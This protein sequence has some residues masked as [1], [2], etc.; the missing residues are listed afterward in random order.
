MLTI[1]QKDACRLLNADLASRLD[2]PEREQQDRASS[3]GRAIDSES[4]TPVL[5]RH[6]GWART[7]K[8]VA[9][10]LA[11]TD[12]AT[13]RRDEFEACGLYAFVLRS[14]DDPDKYR[15]AG[16]CCRDRFCI[17]CATERSCI[18]AANVVEIIGT[19][20][21]RFLTLT[22]KTHAEPLTDQLDK[23][24]RSFQALR[25]RRLWSRHVTGGVAFL[26]LKWSD[27]G[28]RW[29][30]HLHCLIEGTWIDKKELQRCWREITGDS[31]VVDIR[32]PKSATSVTRYVT[33]YASK[34][35]N[36]TYANRPELLDEAIIALAG[37]KLCVTFGRW[38]GKLLTATP[39]EGSWERIGSLEHFISFAADGNQEA[40]DIL[41]C[42]TDRDLTD[43]LAR[44]PPIIRTEVLEP[45][46]D[47]QQDF[48]GT[49]CAD[50]TFMYRYG[51]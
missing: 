33:K 43:L 10:A 21:V 51:G 28:Q 38:R 4:R 13:S 19:H 18:I 20:E 39:D 47:R 24:Y 23:L 3:A 32:L 31:F 34:P 26:E 30:P 35:I 44:A 45:Q 5:F 6:S 46:A 48:F 17:P 27:S 29:H 37:R 7:R 25:R 50:G 42:L 8:L 41:A 15:I 36:T 49:W 1:E 12:Q 9:E 14:I 16:S 11:R 40:I 2:S 22:I